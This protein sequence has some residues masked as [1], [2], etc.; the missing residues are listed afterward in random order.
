MSNFT[1]SSTFTLFPKT[2]TSVENAQTVKFTLDTPDFLRFPSSSVR[3]LKEDFAVLQLW[4][5]S[6]KTQ[7][8]LSPLKK[9]SENFTQK[10]KWEVEGKFYLSLLQKKGDFGTLLQY[11]CEA[12]TPRNEFFR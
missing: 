8:C 4:E 1:A 9:V 6:H 3:K 11:I 12:S 5:M 7:M 2:I 10:K